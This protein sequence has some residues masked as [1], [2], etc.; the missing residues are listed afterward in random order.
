MLVTEQ[1]RQLVWEGL[2]DAERDARYSDAQAS[3]YRAYHRFIRVFLGI[4]TT[5]SIA[6][7]VGVLAAPTFVAAAAVVGAVAA[8]EGVMDLGRKSGILAFVSTE[9]GELEQK[10]H[11]LWVESTRKDAD[12]AV[13]LHR[14]ENLQA[15][16]ERVRL[17]ED[18][19]GV[20]TSRKLNQLTS[21]EAYEAL[22]NRYE[23][24]D[25]RSN[26]GKDG[27]GG[28]AKAIRSQAAGDAQGAISKEPA[29]SPATS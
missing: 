3:L 23:V 22:A 16:A 1:T 15:R 4:S 2:I 21:R 19:A 14:F 28:Q 24:D 8:F 13:V 27:E 9:Y 25:R 20:S 10:W 18:A 6:Y 7:A 12:D 29:T 5:G 26:I 17:R 11:R